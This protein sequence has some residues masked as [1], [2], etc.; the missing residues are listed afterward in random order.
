MI[1][2]VFISL[3][4]IFAVWKRQDWRDW[5]KYLPV[6]MY[7]A[8]GNLTYN[9][10]CANYFLWRLNPDALSNHSLTEMLYTFIIF[11]G[12]ALMFLSKY[13]EG[14]GTKSLAKH[15]SFWIIIYILVEWIFT[16]TNSIIYQYGWG[17][18]W[19]ATF[20]VIMF[21]M[22]RLFHKKSL[23][24]LLLSIPIAFIWI[25]LF[26]VPVHIPIEDRL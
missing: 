7:F 11:P 16:Y 20:D 22:L 10:L 6:M 4:V 18:I 21:P 15:Y 14:E 13:P 19:S 26:D 8:L 9:F 5:E 3:V 2:H 12:T 17:L 25:F 24:A 23:I 1:V